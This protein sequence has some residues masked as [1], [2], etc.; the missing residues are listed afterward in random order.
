M[1]IRVIDEIITPIEA[2]LPRNMTLGKMLE[3]RDEDDLKDLMCFICDML[4]DRG[5]DYDHMMLI[6]KYVDD[7]E[8]TR[9][10][11]VAYTVT[12]TGSATVLATSEENARELVHNMDNHSL[13]FGECN[14]DYVVEN[15]TYDIDIDTDDV[16]IKRQWKS[17]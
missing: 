17:S 10:Y 13:M 3:D 8:L 15:E 12:I 5:A 6:K 14:D 16:E 9:E 11:E 1:A 7:I 2:A 4:Q